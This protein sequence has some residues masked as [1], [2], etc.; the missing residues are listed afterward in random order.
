MRNSILASPISRTEYCF[1]YHVV[2]DAFNGECMAEYKL[3]IKIG[4]HEFEAEGPADGVQS[5]F[6]ACKELIGSVAPS[7]PKPKTE[8]Q[9]EPEKTATP[10]NG[11]AGGVLALEKI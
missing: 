11:S 4:E 8:S 6:A 10:G 9:T 2:L 3:K 1:S 7:P 5:Q